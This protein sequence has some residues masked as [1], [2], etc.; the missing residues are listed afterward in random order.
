MTGEVTGHPRQ[1]AFVWSVYPLSPVDLLFISDIFYLLKCTGL[2][3][4][5]GVYFLGV[6]VYIYSV[7][8]ILVFFF[9]LL[10]SLRNKNIL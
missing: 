8:V 2:F 5:Q 6:G 9:F 4:F 7:E 1:R 10:L 3:S